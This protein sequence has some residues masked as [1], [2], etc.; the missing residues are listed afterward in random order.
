MNNLTIFPGIKWTARN[1]KQQLKLIMQLPVRITS[2]DKS[3]DILPLARFNHLGE[4]L[5]HFRGLSE[6]DAFRNATPNELIVFFQGC[7]L[8]D[9]LTTSEVALW[10]GL[11]TKKVRRLAEVGLLKRYRLTCDLTL[12]KRSELPAIEKLFRIPRPCLN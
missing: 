11:S 10:Y 2:E 6:E 9:L 3:V 5:F 4:P 8:D 12:Y 1:Y 7:R